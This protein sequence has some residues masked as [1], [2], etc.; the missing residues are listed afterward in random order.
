MTPCTGISTKP[1]NSSY[2]TASCTDCSGTK[3]INTSWECYSGYIRSGDKCITDTSGSIP[4][5]SGP[6]CNLPNKVVTCSGKRYCCPQ[7]NASCDN[8]IMC[9]AMDVSIV[10]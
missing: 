2:V 7:A 8:K 5:T 6:T 4:D 10:N 3:T 1:T 9:W